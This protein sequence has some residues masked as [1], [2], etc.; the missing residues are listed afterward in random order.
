MRRSDARSRVRGRRGEGGRSWPFGARRAPGRRLSDARQSSAGYRGRHLAFAD[1]E[2][3]RDERAPGG[4]GLVDDG[5]ERR[6][7]HGGHDAKTKVDEATACA[8]MPKGRHSS[9]LFFR[10]PQAGLFGGPE[11]TAFGS[12]ANRFHQRWASRDEQTVVSGL[13]SC[14]FSRALD[15]LPN[16]AIT[17][18]HSVRRADGSL[19]WR[20]AHLPSQPERVT[21]T[22]F[23][24]RGS[25]RCGAARASRGRAARSRRDAMPLCP[26]TAPT[27]VPRNIRPRAARRWRVGRW[28]VRWGRQT[29]TG[30]GLPRPPRPLIRRSP[31]KRPTPPAWRSAFARGSITNSARGAR[32]RK[33]KRSRT[34]SSSCATTS[35]SWRRC[36]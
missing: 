21:C 10:Y 14:V 9:W 18:A 28:R 15:R 16:N 25:P 7:C 3:A 5:R 31:R 6:G 13:D 32:T 30:E 23:D 35:V 26:R 19:R 22:P 2:R 20:R 11:S 34:S 12:T 33:G 36:W 24:A 29:R 4:G 27:R 8:E 1:R 17:T